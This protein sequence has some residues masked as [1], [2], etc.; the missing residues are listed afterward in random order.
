MLR[1]MLAAIVALGAFLVFEAR[2]DASPYVRYGIQD[3]A[4]LLGGPGTFDE[5]LDQVDA[6]GADVVRVN[7]RWDE[8]AA[9]R[10]AKPSS[11]LDP[12]YH[13][14]AGDVLLG[15]PARARHRAGRDAGRR[16]SLGQRRTR[17]E[18][19]ADEPELVRE[20][21]V[22]SGEALPPTCAAG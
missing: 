15:G 1:I 14:A 10:P 5:R 6:L 2:A 20:L 8:I 21:R 16:T 12:A 17:R 13:W 11:H 9:K 3:D 19:G 4:W 18:L 22:R 7:L